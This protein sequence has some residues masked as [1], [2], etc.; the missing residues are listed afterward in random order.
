MQGK[1]VRQCQVPRSRAC[2]I[3][4]P[5]DHLQWMSPPFPYSIVVIVNTVYCSTALATGNSHKIHFYLEIPVPRGQY[6]YGP[7]RLCMLGLLLLGGASSDNITLCSF[8]RWEFSSHILMEGQPFG[9]PLLY[10]VSVWISF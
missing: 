2:P 8:L 9:D 5:C 4:Y 6:K 7:R 1:F 3:V 10:R